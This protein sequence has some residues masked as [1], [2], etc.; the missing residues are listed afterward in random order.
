MLF[1]PNEKKW[2]TSWYVDSWQGY[3][4]VAPHVA[5]SPFRGPRTQYPSPANKDGIER[6]N[7]AN[8][9]ERL[10]ILSSPP[11]IA[12]LHFIDYL[13]VPQHSSKC[14]VH[15]VEQP[16][17]EQKHLKAAKMYIY[18][19]FYCLC[20]HIIAVAGGFMCV[21]C[22]SGVASD[23]VHCQENRSSITS[24]PSSSQRKPFSNDIALASKSPSFYG[25][26]CQLLLFL[27]LQNCFLES[28]PKST[29]RR[30]SSWT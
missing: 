27:F 21:L 4:I 10:A 17:L 2:K 3:N 9:D 25:Y 24:S 16:K 15:R 29:E 13:F 8:R 11:L 20:L 6:G 5:P 12:S 30:F 28:L 22:N 1:R 23:F 7:N 14:G 26:P 19:S 18:Y